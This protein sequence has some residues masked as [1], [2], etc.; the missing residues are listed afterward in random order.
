MQPEVVQEDTG[1]MAPAGQLW[2]TAADLCRWAAFL[3]AGDDDVLAAGTLAEMRTA[4]S[5]GGEHGLGLQLMS[6]GLAGHTGSMPGFVAALWVN[7]AAD[8]GAVVLVNCTNGLPSGTLAADLVR[9]VTEREPRIPEPW[10]PVSDADPE[11]LALT[12]PWYWGPTPFVL[13]LRAGRD[14]ELAP[15]S[16]GGRASRFVPGDD[17]G[18]T[19]LDGYYA[20]ETLRAVRAE[21][22]TVT[23]LD[24]GSF[25]LTRGPYEPAEVVPGGASQEGWMSL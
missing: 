18:W 19:G 7:A 5:P 12:G 10:Q 2:S 23:H 3:A 24:L 17:G 15:V 6:P 14:L 22:G 20:G 25:V 4:A 13:R 11:L 8:V 9:I 21:D 16:A 1:V